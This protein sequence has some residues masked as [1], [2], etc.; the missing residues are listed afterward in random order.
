MSEGK[1]NQ[2]LLMKSLLRGNQINTHSWFSHLDSCNRLITIN[3]SG[4]QESAIDKS[5][6]QRTN[7]M[8]VTRK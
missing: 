1:G 5:Q 7:L 6:H 2:I 8:T 4:S 3:N